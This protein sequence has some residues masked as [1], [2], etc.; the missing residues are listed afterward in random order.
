MIETAYKI[1]LKNIDTN[2]I[3]K[4]ANVIDYEEYRF[5]VS[6]EIKHGVY[7]LYD[8]CIVLSME[9]ER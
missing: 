6:V 9:V 5:G 8:R 4:L 3:F 2:E 1:T 7:K